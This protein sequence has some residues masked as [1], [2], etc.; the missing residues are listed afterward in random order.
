MVV[1]NMV[2]I[3]LLGG[4]I[5]IPTVGLGHVADLPSSDTSPDSA[6]PWA[7]TEAGAPGGVPGLGEIP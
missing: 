3:N 2:T 4:R 7:A 5:G 1:G 6:Q